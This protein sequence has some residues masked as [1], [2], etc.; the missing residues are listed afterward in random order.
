MKEALSRLYEALNAL[1]SNKPN[2]RSEQDR[3]WAI[4]ITDLEKTIAFFEKYT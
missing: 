2:D 4:A 3:I 1:R